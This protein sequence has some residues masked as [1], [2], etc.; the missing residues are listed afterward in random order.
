M[1]LSSKGR[2]AVMAMADL[3]SQQRKRPVSLAEIAARQNVSLSYLEQLFA[4]LRRNG[5]VK[6]AR[7]PGG[8]YVLGRPPEQLLVADVVR[9]IDAPAAGGTCVPA[10]PERCGGGRHTCATHDLWAG[11]AQQTD[12]FLSSISLADLCE[13]RIPRPARI[14]PLERPCAPI[15]AE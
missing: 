13:G 12:Y 9:A 3:A 8:G 10:S 11:L 14:R 6:S 1:R 7:G 4:K 5:L 15:A 2:Y